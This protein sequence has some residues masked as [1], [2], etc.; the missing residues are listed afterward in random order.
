MQKPIQPFYY[1][2]SDHLQYLLQR[3]MKSKALQPGKQI[4][5]LLFTSGIHTQIQ[6]IHS[7]L[8]G[9]YAGCGDLISSKL[10]FHR[11]RKPNAF[12][13]NWMISSSAFNGDCQEAILFFTQMQE[14]GVLPNK[15][16]F[17]CMLKACVGLLDIKKGKELHGI[18][19]IRGF[20]S[21][22][23]VANAL[24]DMYCKCG[25]LE[26]GR[27]VF[28][29]MP[30]RD[31]ASW[32][33]MLSGYS[34]NGEL[35]QSAVLFE[36]MKFGGMEPNEFTWNAMIAGFAQNGECSRALELFTEMKKA[37]LEPDL[38]TWNAMV[39]GFAQNQQGIKAMELFGEMLAI[40][41]KPNAVTVA[42]LLPACGSMGSLQRGR[43]VHALIY[44]RGLQLNIFTVTALI[45]MYSKC[46]SVKDARKVFDQITI[47]NVASWNAMISCYGKHGFVDSSIGLFER[48]QKEGVLAN[49]V[50]FTCLLSAC[51]HG[52][53]VEKGL[54]IFESMK[55]VYGVEYSKEHYACI[56]DL[57]C[58]SGRLIEAYKL[59]KKIPMKIND[60]VMGAFF[61][62]CRIYG[63]SDMAKQLVEDIKQMEFK[64]PG[65]F[66]L[67]SNIYAAD[68][69]WE[70]VENV[71]KLMK[72]KGIWKRPGC[73]WVEKRDEMVGETGLCER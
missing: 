21:D 52:G 57:L 68:G 28:D 54:E 65:G 45:D 29:G 67:L 40:G 22:V 56:V 69:K 50:T 48:M 13:F 16:T 46:G 39:A 2:T 33:A 73:S 37:A 20:E 35:E 19:C 70:G 53:L 60:S 38:V 31:V 71:R 72:E 3:C 58:R 18:I 10:L 66:V 25:E 4:H 36:R 63:R 23:S 64:K 44:R 17:S 9:M 30:E 5:A 24:I 8:I 14:A 49:Q 42:G 27:R 55:E 47:R 34:H 41:L 1:I 12:A 32:T 26:V 62:G 51:S 43:L 59:M 11:I 6:S 15:F 61:N 7:K